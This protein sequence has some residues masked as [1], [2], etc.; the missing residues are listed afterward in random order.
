MDRPA[1]VA[2]RRADRRSRLSGEGADELFAGYDFKYRSHLATLERSDSIRRF[3]GWLPET[4][5][6]F[7]ST[8]LGRLRRRAHGSPVAEIVAL[9]AQAFPGDQRRPRGLTREQLLRLRRRE[10]EIGRELVRPQRDMLSTLL[11]FDVDWMLGESLLQKADKMSMAASI[12][13]RTPFID[14]PLAAAAARLDSR[15]KLGPESGKL[16]LR[17]CLARRVPEPLDRPKRGF[18]MPLNAWMRGELREQVESE[19]FAESAACFAHLDR[20]LV[21]RAWDDFQAGRWGGALAFY[22]LW[23]YEAWHRTVVNAPKPAL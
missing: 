7:P 21:R 19:I 15:L 6:P 10:A 17:E 13:L 20:A 11:A 23:L 22:S 16:V 2:P 12:E 18:G 8:R 1:R 4:S 3:A 14:V 5:N 9:R